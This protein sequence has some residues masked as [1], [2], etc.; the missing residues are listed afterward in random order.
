MINQGGW[1]EIKF[2]GN[3]ITAELQQTD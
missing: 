1:I 3:T 2:D